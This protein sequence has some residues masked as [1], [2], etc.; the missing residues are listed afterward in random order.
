MNLLKIMPAALL[1]S[2]SLSAF[3]QDDDD[4]LDEAT[5]E[6]TAEVLVPATPTEGKYFHRVQIGF[7]GLNAKYTNNSVER[8]PGTPESEKYFLKGVNVGWMGD[9]SIAKKLPLYL[10]LGASL[11]WQTGSTTGDAVT[12]RTNAGDGVVNEFKYNVQA[13]TLAIPVGV[14]YQFRNFAGVKDLTVAPLLGIYARFNIVAKRK[15]TKTVTEYDLYDEQGNDVI[16]SVN[17]FVENKTLMEDER[18]GGWM[19]GRPHAGRLLQLGAQVGVNAFYKH[20]SFGLTYMHDVLP[21][22]RH[23]SPLGLTSKAT[24]DG[25]NVPS[26]G[27][28]CDMKIATSPSFAVTFGY[29]F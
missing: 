29:I 18:R 9:L 10:E 20:Y 6:E 11:A 14:S 22:A 17:D 26:A 7:T 4:L 25:G 12:H 2:V 19:E 28:G 21:F 3:A 15:Q 24:D 27:T 8:H 5:D 23:S 16:K 1:L 13:F